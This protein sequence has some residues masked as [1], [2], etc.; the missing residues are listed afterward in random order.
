MGENKANFILYKAKNTD[1][2]LASASLP[3]GKGRYF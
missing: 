3:A 1:D 2:A